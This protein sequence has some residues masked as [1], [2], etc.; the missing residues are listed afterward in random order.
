[1]GEKIPC[2]CWRTRLWTS[3]CTPPSGFATDPTLRNW[4][5]LSYLKEIP[6]NVRLGLGLQGPSSPRWTPWIMTS[7]MGTSMFEPKCL[8]ESQT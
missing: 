1:M 7:S 5:F 2:M 4:R 3:A 6:E 8:D